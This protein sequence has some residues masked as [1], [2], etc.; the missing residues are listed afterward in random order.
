MGPDPKA[1]KAKAIQSSE[2]LFGAVVQLNLWF[3]L[4]IHGC[5]NVA[6]TRQSK[7][8]GVSSFRGTLSKRS[9]RCRCASPAAAAPRLRC[10]ASSAEHVVLAHS[11]LGKVLPLQPRPGLQTP[12]LDPGPGQ[13]A[14]GSSSTPGSRRASLDGWSG[15]D[16][17]E[18]SHVPVSKA[19]A[20]DMHVDMSA[21]QQPQQARANRSGANG[22]R[23]RAR[24]V[25][26]ANTLA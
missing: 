11:E 3:L 7:K 13:P 23:W 17:R 18:T 21:L 24:D 8:L 6:Q 4:R 9:A 20:L 19:D 14:R 16:R 12:P 10:A 26:C 22:R 1:T 15:P 2:L 25:F 5:S